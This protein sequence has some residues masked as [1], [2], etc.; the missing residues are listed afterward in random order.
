MTRPQGLQVHGALAA[1]LVLLVLA[2]VLTVAHFIAKSARAETV[3]E[4]IHRT[5]HACCDHRDC[6]AVHAW[7]SGPVWMVHWH[8]VETPYLGQ[9]A[10]SPA[11][12]VACGTPERIR[13]LFIEGGIS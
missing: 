6:V 1:M 2:L 9:I 3:P 10:P 4:W 13:C 12:T 5:H 8:G 7:K 11:E